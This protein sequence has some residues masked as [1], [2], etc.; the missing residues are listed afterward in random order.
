MNDAARRRKQ[1]DC[2]FASRSQVLELRKQYVFFF[3]Q[4]IQTKI[5][6]IKGNKT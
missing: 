5:E 4:I 3:F 6:K 2:Y 1:A